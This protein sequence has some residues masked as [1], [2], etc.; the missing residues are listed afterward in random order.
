ME[1]GRNLHNLP[2]QALDYASSSG[3]SSRALRDTSGNIQLRALENIK[4]ENQPALGVEPKYPSPAATLASNN[5]YPG[6]AALRREEKARRRERFRDP[7]RYLK[8]TKYLE[9]R[10]KQARA[11]PRRGEEEPVWPDN[12]EDAFHA[13]ITTGLVVVEDFFL[14]L[15]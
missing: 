11:D 15:L 14:T 3:Q 1:P 8:D 9:Y 4:P 10:R 6:R 12:V 13:G 5:H 2:A 7:H